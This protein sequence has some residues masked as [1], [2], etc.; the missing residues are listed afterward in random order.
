MR[1]KDFMWYLIWPAAELWG[2]LD[3]LSSIKC[4]PSI[5][6]KKLHERLW[7]CFSTKC[8]HVHGVRHMLP[9]IHHVSSRSGTMR[10]LTII[11]SWWDLGRAHSKWNQFSLMSQQG[12]EFWIWNISREE[13]QESRCS[14]AIIWRKSHIE[15]EGIFG[16]H[17]DLWPE[18]KDQNG[19]EWI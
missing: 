1:G 18:L 12:V 9:G 19:K 7:N 16:H 5:L 10:S 15:K 2:P 13:N 3:K 8:L 11:E 17:I 14:K 6:R 4:P